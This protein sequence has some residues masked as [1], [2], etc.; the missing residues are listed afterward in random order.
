[1][2]MDRETGVASSTRERKEVRSVRVIVDPL[3][4]VS[5]LKPPSERPPSSLEEHL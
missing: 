3:T 1:M 4:T 5:I 2:Y